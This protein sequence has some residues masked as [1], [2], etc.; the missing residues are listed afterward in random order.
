MYKRQ[1][2]ISNDDIDEA[3]EKL[4]TLAGVFAI[5]FVIDGLSS[6]TVYGVI[7]SAN[8]LFA[9]ADFTTIDIKIEGMI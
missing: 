8:P 3:I 6:Y 1:V 2:Q 9:N 7:R 4:T 5:F